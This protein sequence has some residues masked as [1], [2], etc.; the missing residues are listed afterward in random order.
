[1]LDKIASITVHKEEGGWLIEE[2][3]GRHEVTPVKNIKMTRQEF[4]KVWFKNSTSS[5]YFLSKCRPSLLVD[6]ENFSFIYA[7]KWP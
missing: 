3:E 2:K 1:M 4:S 5:K 6:E 7:L